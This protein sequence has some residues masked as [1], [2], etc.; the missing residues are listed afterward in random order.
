MAMNYSNNL[1]LVCILA[2]M[3]I[4]SAGCDTPATGTTGEEV[5]RGDQRAG[6]NL[7]D[8]LVNN[9]GKE[10]ARTRRI[11]IGDD[12][13]AMDPY[14]GAKTEDD[15]L[16][17]R[18]KICLDS[19]VDSYFWNIGHGLMPKPS[20]RFDPELGKEANRDIGAGIMIREC[21]KAGIEIFG[22]LRM[23]DAHDHYLGLQA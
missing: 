2:L 11:I 10:L 14:Y 21:R 17:R 20:D 19:Q 22:S 18:F 5:S 16:A 9:E 4:S 1:F 23:N 3:V 7:T 13:D 6:Q 15:F 12:S 8:Q